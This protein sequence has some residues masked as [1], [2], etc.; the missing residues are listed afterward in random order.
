MPQP[1][2]SEESEPQAAP[3]AG[4]CARGGAGRWSGGLPAAAETVGASGCVRESHNACAELASLR[5][6]GLLH[7]LEPRGQVRARSATAVSLAGAPRGSLDR[8]SQRQ[9]YANHRRAGPGVDVD[10]AAVTLNDDAAG[11]SSP[12]PVP[13]P[14]SLVVKNAS[15]A[16]AA[17]SG[18]IPGPVSAMSTTSPSRRPG[19]QRQHTLSVH[20][21]DGVVDEIRPDLVSSPGNASI[22]AGPRR[23]RARR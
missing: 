16:R 21:V 4:S 8:C 13:L 2:A 1:V 11:M 9:P 15:K 6:M 23:T 18:A 10:R 14:T 7:G 5:F 19:R 22:E 17:T 20:R 12:R 3:I